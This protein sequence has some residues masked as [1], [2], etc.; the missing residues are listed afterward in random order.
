ME[1]SLSIRKMTAS[2]L[3]IALGIVIPM[4]SPAKIVIPPASFTL[5]SHVPVFMAMFIS[6]GAA[7]AVAVGTT[8]GFLMGPFP[9]VI[10]LR[11]ATHVIFATFGA[12]WL[13]TRPQ[14]LASPVKTQAFSLI[15]G[16]IHAACEVMV[17]SLFYFGGSM[18]DSYYNTGF[19]T[20]VLLLVGV[21]SVVHSMLDFLITLG[22]L[23][24]VTRQKGVAPLFPQY[25][26]AGKA[27][28]QAD[29]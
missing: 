16:L 25:H 23:S 10:A 5:A 19:L 24:V 17:V 1:R 29:M 9:L 20:S 26:P 3:L 4:F 6:P 18:A 8:L 14:T 21:G 13:K 11:A 28:Q 2:A 7:A 15:I 22:L 27:R 12:F